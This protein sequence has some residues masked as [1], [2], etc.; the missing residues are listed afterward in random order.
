MKKNPYMCFGSFSEATAMTI[1]KASRKI[2]LY[3]WQ[4][5]F[6]TIH[7]PTFPFSSYFS[8][9]P[10]KE[11]HGIPFGRLYSKAGTIV[12]ASSRLRKA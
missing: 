1:F 7:N 4:I 9:H 6:N 8:I 12:T 5:T 2:T 3:L 11:S 10:V